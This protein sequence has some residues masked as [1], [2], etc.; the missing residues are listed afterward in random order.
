MKPV[1]QGAQ[2]P[3]TINLTETKN[4]N[5]VKVTTPFDLTGNT[6]IEV[7]FKVGS[8][9]VSKKKTVG[10]GVLIIGAEIDGKISSTLE[11][12]DSDGFAPGDGDIEIFETKGAGVV[13]KFQI[14]KAFQVIEKI[15]P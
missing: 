14:L 8:T 7:C 2:V 15:C 4:Q 5:G 1:I 12:A 13:T 6:E 3:F 10:A 9:V 11:I